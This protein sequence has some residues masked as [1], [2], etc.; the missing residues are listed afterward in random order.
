MTGLAVQAGVSALGAILWI[1]LQIHATLA[2]GNEAAVRRAL[3]E[4]LAVLTDSAVAGD[5]AIS[6]TASAVLRIG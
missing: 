5:A 1:R 3:R 4:A 6:A 2:A